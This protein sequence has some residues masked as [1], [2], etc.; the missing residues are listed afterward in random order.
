M[1][2]QVFLARF[3]LVV[4]CGK[5]LGTEA[6]LVLLDDALHIIIGEEPRFGGGPRFVR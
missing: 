3:K 2:K 5:L 1:P 4:A 6:S